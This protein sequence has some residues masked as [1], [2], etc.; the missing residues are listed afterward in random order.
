M[1]VC[2]HDVLITSPETLCAAQAVERA[3]QLRAEESK[4]LAQMEAQLVESEK[5]RC[6]PA[7]VLFVVIC[8]LQIFLKSL[9][10]DTSFVLRRHSFRQGV[11]DNT[12]LRLCVNDLCFE[13]ACQATGPYFL[14]KF[15]LSIPVLRP[16]HKPQQRPDS[17]YS[18]DLS[19]SGMPW[20]M[21][22]L[23]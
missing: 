19:L 13:A 6:F 14:R 7:H 5:E 15:V 20:R 9:S 17:L 3:G 16:L 21:L 2:F 10:E 4:R 22:L 1:S 8:M 18:G 12:L 23:F 11:L